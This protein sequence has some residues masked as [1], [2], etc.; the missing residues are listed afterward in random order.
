MGTW[1]CSLWISYAQ[2]TISTW[3]NADG[4]QYDSKLT[5]WNE[6]K[7]RQ[8]FVNASWKNVIKRSLKTSL[9]SRYCQHPLYWREN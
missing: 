5:I 7:Y 9:Y 2:K 3:C 6:C 4:F 1:L 8:R